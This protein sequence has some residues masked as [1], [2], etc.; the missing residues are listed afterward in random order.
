VLALIKGLGR[1]G[2][3]RLLL[4]SARHR[5]AHVALSVGYLLPHKRALVPALEAA[6]VPTTCL[7]TGGRL[8][9]RWLGQLRRLLSSGECDVVHVHSPVLAIATR[10]ALRTI[11]A[12][13][14]PRLVSTE[15]NVWSSHTVPTR[16][17]D[18]LTASLD[19]LHLAV[20]DA[21]RA[22][23]P[24]RLRPGT[25]VVRYGVEL[26]EIRAAA[27]ARE[28]TRAALGLP[29]GAV[30]VGTVA[31]LRATKGYPDLLAAARRVVDVDD[32]VFFVSVGQG[33]LE[34]ELRRRSSDLGLGERFR[35]LGFRDDAVHVTAAFDVFCLASHHEGLPIALMEALA[36]GLPIVATTVGGVPELLRDDVDAVLVP[37]KRPD[38]LADALLSLLA[39][40]PRRERLAAAARARAPELGA[41]RA[42]RQIEAVYDELVGD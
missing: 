40:E 13:R 16:V 41:E 26:D 23:M 42:V 2:A 22:S 1:G 29:D 14:R 39:D 9:P 34:E 17:A 25:R 4:S 3:E 20:S 15:H 8:D 36:L 35:F 37:P 24:A 21:V 32:R 19:D 12:G 33:P 30:V 6:G 10:L 31:N 7:A 38:L 5:D 27:S 18:F 28:Q 11:P